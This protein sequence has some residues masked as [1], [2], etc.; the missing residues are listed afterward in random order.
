M[1]LERI[2]LPGFG[3][4]S[5]FQAEF[6]PGL[7]LFH[8]MNEAGK[9]TLQQ[10]IC[11]LLFGF[12]D[13]DRARPEETARHERFR[14]WALGST[15]RGCLTYQLEDGA[16]YEVRRDF[17]SS[18]VPTQLIDPATGLDVSSHFGQGRHGN[19]PFARKHLGMSRAVFQSCAFISQGEVFQVDRSTPRQIGD[20]IAS[21]AD[22]A[23]RDVS[24]SS[25]ID[26]LDTLLARIGSDRARTAEL[27][28]ARE[29]LR[30]A[31]A[32]LE[33]VDAARAAVALKCA[34]LEAARERLARLSRDITRHQVLF[35]LVRSAALTRRLN[36]LA[37]ADGAME[38][39]QRTLTE[40]KQFQAFPAHFRDQIVALRE[41]RRRLQQ[42]LGDCRE[43]LRESER[44]IDEAGRV[45]HDAL[46]LSV[47]GLSE[48]AL[49]GLRQL[50]Y[51]QAEAPSALRH[52]AGRFLAFARKALGLLLLVL[53][54]RR[55]PSPSKEAAVS[56]EA[57]R[58]SRDEAQALLE[59]HVRYLE[60]RPLMLDLAQRRQSVEDTSVALSACE[61]ELTA[62]LSVAGIGGDEPLD[63]GVGRFIEGCYKQRLYEVAEAAM[64]EGERHR[65]AILAGR[66]PEELQDQLEES[67]SRLGK[68]LAAH[69][70]LNDCRPEGS[71]GDLRA[72]LAELE[73]EQRG[74]ELS[75]ARLEE[76]VRSAL[77]GHRAR[78]EVEED[79]AR[80]RLE[81]QR[82][83]RARAAAQMA[84]EGI[85]EA[86]VAVYRDFAPAV[87]TFLSD[88]FSR[89]TAGRYLRAHVDPASL[90]ISLLLPETDQVVTDPP[91][92]R[93]TLTLAYVLMRIGLAQ[94]MSAI[95]E[96]VPLVLD[97]PFSEIDGER[98]LRLLDFLCNLSERTQVLLFTKDPAIVERFQAQADGERH[99][100]HRLHLHTLQRAL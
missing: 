23:R 61:N 97:D 51:R 46:H 66:S 69:P 88:G 37:D 80:S 38:R 67:D 19:L 100:L 68:L 9:S 87:N 49:A 34:E 53:F 48:E 6:A 89:I 45:E 71:Q 63:N 47:A 52:F 92:S 24:A 65:T 60:L 13:G 50:A 95:G 74:L 28:R 30:L 54:H 82:L 15:F 39:A 62:L 10:A 31:E 59:R 41:R 22:S 20:A 96:P 70:E 5:G 2:E 44:R 93:G 17:A 94:H 25:A 35:L 91:V 7:N 21:L 56:Q 55:V 43:Q 77:R 58:L 3:C 98:L 42:Q 33:A 26:R 1:R 99:R 8:G 73:E 57:P 36:D 16:S 18:D 14:P 78:A 90:R 72:A 86:M 83:D 85:A 79:V 84:R 64:E 32:E 75:V 12:Y 11:A 29:C 76:E 40:C 4:L 27:P 81:T